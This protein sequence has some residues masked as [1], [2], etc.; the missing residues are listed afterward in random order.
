MLF[1]R[2]VYNCLFLI[3]VV[4]ILVFLFISLEVLINCGLF[5]FLWGFL[6]SVVIER[7]IF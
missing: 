5:I 6:V 4:L 1:V 3:Y 7:F 2:L